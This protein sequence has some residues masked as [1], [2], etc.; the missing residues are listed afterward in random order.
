M[1]VRG[2][3]W[4]R[5]RVVDAGSRVQV[6]VSGEIDLFTADHLEHVLDARVR[7]AVPARPVV[8][9][10]A[11]VEF[12]AAVGARVL[13][14]AAGRARERGVEFRCSPRSA[15]VD[16]ALDVCGWGALAPTPEPG[17]VVRPL[18]SIRGTGR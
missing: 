6:L 10:L 8:V 4:L 3:S 18:R 14:G 13:V 1:D 2:S 7:T 9:D 17:G 5:V 15:A 12:C 11:G 16:L